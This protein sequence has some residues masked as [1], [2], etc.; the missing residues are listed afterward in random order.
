MAPSS[1]RAIAIEAKKLLLDGREQI[2]RRHDEGGSG[3]EIGNLLTDLADTVVL[4]LLRGALEEFQGSSEGPA[5]AKDLESQF[6]LVALG[7]FGRRDLAPYSDVD[8]MVLIQPQADETVKPLVTR[9][10]QDLYDAGFQ[11]GLSVRDAREATQLALGDA[12]IFTALAE[13]RYLAGNIDLFQ[14]FRDRLAK[15]TQRRGFSLLESSLASR[16]EERSKYG[17]TVFLLC[18]NVK[19]SRGGLRDLHLI[20]WIAFARFGETDFDRIHQ[21]KALNKKDLEQVLAAREFLH[22][23]RNELHF[24][25]GKSQDLLSREEQV[26]IAK[27]FGYEGDE[28]VLP[29]EQFMRDYFAHSSQIRYIAANFTETARSRFGLRDI[30]G[31]VFSF[32]VGGDFR[33]GPVHVTATRQGQA[34]LAN[35]LVDI[36]RLMDLANAYNRR[37]DHQTWLTI[38]EAMIDIDHFELDAEVAQRFMA[39]LS[40]TSRLGPL[41]RRMHELRVLEKIVPPMKRAR[42]LLQFNEYHKYT[43]DEHSIRAVEAAVGWIGEENKIGEIY[44]SLKSPRLLH[45][46][47]LLHD[48]GKGDKRDHSELG[49]ELAEVTCRQLQLSDEE[50][51]LVCFLVRHHLRMSHLAFYRDM[52]D[53]AIIAEL[54]AT[55]QSVETLKMLFVLTCSD[56]AAVGPDVLNDWKQGLLLELYHRTL[57]QLTG[58]SDLDPL[59]HETDAVKQQVTEQLGDAEDRDEL[60]GLLQLLPTA[61]VSQRSAAEILRQIREWN[62]LHDRDL[63]V[64]CRTLPEGTAV[65][66]IVAAVD[67]P[68]SGFFHRITG[69]LTSARMEILSVDAVALGNQ[70]IVNRFLVKDLEPVVELQEVRQQK[71]AQDILRILGD[72]QEPVPPFRKVWKPA[73]SSLKTTRHRLPTRVRIDN[74]TSEGF[75]IVDVFAHD[76]S[77]LLYA[78]SRTLFELQLEVHYAKVG[79]FLDQVVDVFYVTDGEGAKV[80]DHDRIRAIIEDLTRTVESVAQGPSQ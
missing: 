54:A 74:D 48:L 70:R 35:S 76:A 78:I 22:R 2:Q 11:L 33:V 12:T 32:S 23:V 57:N 34:K 1:I 36:L 64:S 7:G 52:N 39:F 10:S 24:F 47:L 27:K 77:G 61:L 16:R 17:E 4:K 43:V 62:Q 73:Q 63:S 46:A 15:L 25:A 29:V 68:Q 59:Q 44:R 19:R 40:E 6:S 75:T 20:R 80:Y 67:R 5:S 56:L 26:R 65:E 13:S 42:C 21:Q 14:S 66:Y 72:P 60:L 71:L 69:T 38:R 37:I 53:N 50:T 8:L 41:L 18:P 55:V 28:G 51:D 58:Q 3:T 49:E 9:L 79:T 30:V 31:P 45:L